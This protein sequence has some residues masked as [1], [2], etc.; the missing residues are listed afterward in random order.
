MTLT[1]GEIAEESY[2]LFSPC[3]KSLPLVPAVPAILLQRARELGPGPLLSCHLRS[4]TPRRMPELIAAASGKAFANASEA[5]SKTACGRGREPGHMGSSS[6]L[7]TVRA[8][9]PPGVYRSCL[10]RA[11]G[12]RPD[13]NDLATRGDRQC[14][15][16]VIT[17]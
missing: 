10:G 3:T 15:P 8:A 16:R 9:R 7:I 11:S 4:A 13:L 6:G 2:A 14:R 17:H 1:R 5:G 12:G